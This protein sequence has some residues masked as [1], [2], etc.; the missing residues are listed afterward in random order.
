MI[1]GQLGFDT[2]R[3]VFA[4]GSRVWDEVLILVDRLLV[5]LLVF[6][7]REE[8]V[9]ACGHE[10]ILGQVKESAIDR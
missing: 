4:G 10:W 6:R 5:I 2:L 7:V 8:H 9:C 1:T 3:V